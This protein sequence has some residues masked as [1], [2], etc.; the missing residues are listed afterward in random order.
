MLIPSQE[1][2]FPHVKRPE[3]YSVASLAWYRIKESMYDDAAEFGEYL[4]KQGL[5][6]KMESLGIQMR[7]QHT[8]TPKVCI[9]FGLRLGLISASKSVTVFQFLLLLALC[10]ALRTITSGILKYVRW[11]DTYSPLKFRS[12]S[13]CL[14]KVS[15]PDSRS[16]LEAIGRTLHSRQPGNACPGE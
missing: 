1:R 7:S 2:K 15:K 13:F 3:V 4:E 9:F 6:Q 14:I 5:K 8:I 11:L 12:R 16:S 10:L